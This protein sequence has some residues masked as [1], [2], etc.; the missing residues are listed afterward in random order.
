MKKKLETY[1][2]ETTGVVVIDNPTLLEREALSGFMKKDYRKIKSIIIKI[3]R[4]QIRLNETRF[5]GVKEKELVQKMEVSC[6]LKDMRVA[7]YE[8]KI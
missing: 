5:E 7:T 3:G 8:E 2:R 6:M 4:F 1:E